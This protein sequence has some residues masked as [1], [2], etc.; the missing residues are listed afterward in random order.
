MEEA[1]KVIDIT[2]GVIIFMI[3]LSVNI[4]L[5]ASINNS[6]KEVLSINDID[7]SIIVTQDD[8][9][10]EYVEYSASEVFFMI[11]EMI[12]KTDPNT[13]GYLKDEYSPYNNNEM[14]IEFWENGN[15]SATAIWPKLSDFLNVMYKVDTATGN[16]TSNFATYFT[17]DSKYKVEFEY[18]YQ[19]ADKLNITNHKLI[20]IKFTKM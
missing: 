4:Y 13:V 7:S 16:I 1:N 2:T 17:N 5:Y 20:K 3:A 15:S 11:Q 9:N 18:E 10:N 6:I 19:D 12:Q 8:I 14:D